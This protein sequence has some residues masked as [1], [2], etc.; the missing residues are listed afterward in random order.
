VLARL[1]P[2]LRSATSIGHDRYALELPPECP[3]ERVLGDL[4]ATGA[5]LVSLNPLRETLEDFFVRHVQE[6]GEGARV[7]FGGQRRASH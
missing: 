7:G 2:S 1:Q 6:V 4:V 5:R 3:P